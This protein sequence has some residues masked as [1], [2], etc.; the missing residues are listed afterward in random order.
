ITVIVDGAWS[1]RSYKN[2]RYDALSG[3]ATIIGLRTGRVLYCGMRNKYCSFCASSLKRGLEKPPDHLCF[4][5]YARNDPSTRMEAD[6]I[7][8]GFTKSI[9]SH[10]LIYKS[11]IGDGDSSVHQSIVNN[12]PYKEYGIGVE[13]IECKNHLFRNFCRH[14]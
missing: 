6:I 10:G 14:I 13:K 12:D 9:N 5:N 4:K 3:F 11:F 1:K 2:G 8:E 7:V